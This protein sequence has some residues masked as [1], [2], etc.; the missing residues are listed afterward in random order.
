[1]SGDPYELYDSFAN[2]LAARFRR[3]GNLVSHAPSTGNYHE[4]ILRD[5]LRN[6]LSKRFSIKTG[7]VYKDAEQVSN[8]ID[9]LVVDEYDASAYIFQEGEFAIVRPQSV[10]AAIEVKTKLTRSRFQQALENIASVKRLADDP[11]R[12]FGCVFGYEG[13]PKTKQTIGG[14]FAKVT[15]LAKTPQF[16][17]SLVVFFRDQVLMIAMELPERIVDSGKY[18]GVGPVPGRR[19]GKAGG[20][21]F[22][23]VLALLYT[24]CHIRDAQRRTA[25]PDLSDVSSV[26]ESLIVSADHYELGVGYSPWPPVPAG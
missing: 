15:D 18:R 10:V 24:T 6:F 26:F 7:F 11:S 21:Q 2:E 5:V 1:V 3:V 9:I 22:R 13:T 4:D 23:Y 12:V 8:Q 20:W 25:P 14:W 17:P 16:G 19:R